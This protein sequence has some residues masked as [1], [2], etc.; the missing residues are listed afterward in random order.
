MTKLVRPAKL[1]GLPNSDQVRLE[2]ISSI[3]VSLARTTV[4]ESSADFSSQK[5]IIHRRITPKYC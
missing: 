5:P 1:T 4:D 3:I 2:P